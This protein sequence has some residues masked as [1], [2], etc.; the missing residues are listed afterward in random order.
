MRHNSRKIFF[1]VYGYSFDCYRGDCLLERQ[2]MKLPKFD[3]RY[4]YVFYTYSALYRFKCGISNNVERRRVEVEQA[5]SSA[6]NRQVKVRL[7][8]SVPSLFSEA[9]ETKIHRWLDRIRDKG[10][11]W[12]S[13][14]SEWFWFLNPITAVCLYLI[15]KHYGANVTPCHIALFAIM[16][17]FPADAFLLVFAVFLAEII[18]VF[19]TVGIAV[20][21][22]FYIV[23]NL[24]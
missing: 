15:L 22:I 13:G 2:Q 9:Q 12:H 10:M 14:H 7:A 6:M 17:V 4:L 16:P 1:D 11:V 3:I 18:T 23:T 8:L 19:G 21:I 20:A 5:L 24:I